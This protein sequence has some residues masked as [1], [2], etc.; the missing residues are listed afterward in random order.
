MIERPERQ[1]A[2]FARAGADGI[3]VHAE[4]TPHLHYALHAVR[5]AG[6]RA[7]LAL[8]PG[9]PAAAVA[10]VVDDVDLVLCM[11]VD[12]GWGGQAFLPHSLGKIERLR[13]L[14]GERPVVEVDGGIDAETAAPCARA[15]ATLFVA[16][17]AVFGRRIPVQRFARIAGGGGGRFGAGAANRIVGPD[18]R[19][20]NQPKMAHTVLIVDDHPSFRATARIL[21]EAEGFSVVG[22]AVDGASALTEACRLRPE[23]V[24]LDVQLPDID[25]FHVAEAITALPEPSGDPRL[26]PRPVRLRPAR[27]TL[28][29]SRLRAQG[30]AVGGARAGAAPAGALAAPAPRAARPRRLGHPRRHLRRRHPLGTTSGRAGSSVALALRSAGRGS[31]PGCTPG[32][33]GPTTASAR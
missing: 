27:L 2:D 29:R 18:R 32:G 23:V 28:R 17:T 24:L 14:V 3:T 26:Q 21:L 16:G 30:R 6:C 12:P 9:T 19:G 22:E 5:E 31:A 13:A 11:T 7:G 20:Q 33:G 10:E 25:G 4:A 1:I 15:G 8:N